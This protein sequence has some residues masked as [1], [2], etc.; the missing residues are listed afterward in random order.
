MVFI[1]TYLYIKQHTI[2]GKLYFGKTTKANPIK[3]LGSGKHWK[4]HIKQHGKEHVITLWYQLYDN[5]FDLVADALSMSY[6]LDIVNSKSWL[7]IIDEN[8][9][10]GNGGNK[11]DFSIRIGTFTG[12]SHTEQTKKLLSYYMTGE[13]NHQFGKRGAKS[14]MY[15]RIHSDETKRKM[16]KSQ[17][18][19]QNHNFGKYGTSSRNWGK[20]VKYNVM[21]PTGIIIC[22][23]TIRELSDLFNLKLESVVSNLKRSKSGYKGF[24]ILTD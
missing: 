17:S 14:H 5:V 16:S 9:L 7:N 3:Y 19:E 12:K 23:I 20:G 13:N 4:S 21:S 15:G 8:G 6:S 22:N 18:G 10:D 2:T 24:Y 1:P 11:I